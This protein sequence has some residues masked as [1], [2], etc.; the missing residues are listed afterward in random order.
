MFF[1]AVRI[2]KTK[3]YYVPDATIRFFSPQTYFQETGHGEC[4]VNAKRTSLELADG[5]LMEF[6]YNLGSNLPIM[7]PTEAHT[8]GLIFEDVSYFNDVDGLRSFL[9]VAEQTNQNLTASQKELLLWHW[10]LSHA[11][12]QWVQKLAVQSMN[13]PL[14]LVPKNSTVS[15]CPAPLCTACQLAKQN[16]RTPGTEQRGTVPD[17]DMLL[18]RGHLEPGDMVSIDQYISGI[19][20][21][22]PNTK[23]KEPIRKTGTLVVHSSLI[24]Q[25]ATHTLKIKSH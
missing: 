9:S 8:C 20:G 22:L 14:I 2:I 24:M 17:T 19:P 10:K 21:R 12:F 3:A 5:S 6:P 15:S 13:R 23:G 4:R 1:G 16:R 11:G 18:R 25:P 7:L